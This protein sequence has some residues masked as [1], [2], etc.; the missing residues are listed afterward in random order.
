MS[1]AEL[2]TRIL[3]GEDHLFA[4]IVHR[5]SGYVWALCSS[6]IRNPSDCEDVTQEVF[7]QCYRRLDTLR[8]AAAF[9]QWLSQLA[10]RHCLMWLRTSARRERHLAEYEEGIEA[11]QGRTGEAA[12]ENPA[13]D[14][15]HQG[16]WKAVDA[17]PPDFREAVLLRFAEGYSTEE[18]SSFLG[19]TPAAMRKRIE[20]AQNMLKSMLWD[21]VEPAL[22]KRKHNESLA[23]GIMACVP[24]GKAPWL[25]VTGAVSAA[26]APAVSKL[27]LIGGIAVMSKKM[28]IGL[29]A[30]ALIL[31]LTLLVASRHGPRRAETRPIA[32]VKTGEAFQAAP[33]AAAGNSST[34]EPVKE[35]PSPAPPSAVAAKSAEVSD[36]QG[37]PASVSGLVSDGT[38]NPIA[39]A[40]IF[41]EIGRDR[42]CNDV[43]E[44]YNAKT[45]ADG[46]YEITGID[47]FGSAHVFAS[48]EDYVMQRGDMLDI[49]AGKNAKDVNFTLL[50]AAF[51]VAG[52]VVTENKTPIADASVDTL[53]Y[54][55]DESGLAQTAATGQTT[56]NISGSKFLFAVT[57]KNG[58]FKVAI[59]EEGLCDF[60]V[61]KAGYGPGFFPKIATG[62]TDALFVLRSGGAIAG[63]VTTAD[64]NPV[65][66]ATVRVSG[67]VLPGGLTP[68][69]VRIQ[70]IPV[71][72][73]AVTTDARGDY[74]A[75]GLG[76]DYVY[77]AAVP[78]P[79][80]AGEK[81]IVADNVRGHIVAAM[82]ELDE[83]MFGAQSFG[84]RR[85]DIRVK[86]GQT[87]QGVDLV[88]G[89]TTGATI[90]GTVTDR[91]SG[92][93]V[94]PVVVTAGCA[95]ADAPEEG[96]R[97][98]YWFQTKAGGSAVTNLDGSYVLQIQDLAEARN[99][100][101]SYAFMTEGGSAWEQP[102][103]EIALLE[104]GPGDE[105]ELNFTVD[106]P[107]TVPVRYVG[108]DGSP[109][110]GIDAAIRQAGGR[111]GCGG[112][113]V[114][115]ADG[116]VTFHGVRPFVDL[117]A[118]A[119]R[120]AGS[121]LQTIGV[122]D[123]F[124][125]QPGETVSEV[126]VVCRLSG[127]LGGVG[128]VLVYPDGRV[129]AN[130][131]VVCEGQRVDDTGPPMEGPV[132]TDANGAVH[133]PEIVPEGVYSLRVSFIDGQSGQPYHATAENV[134]IVAG[135]ITDVG[136]L[137]A[138]L[139]KDPMRM[140]QSADWG[141]KANEAISGMYSTALLDALPDP[142]LFWKTGLALY[143]VGRYQEALDVFSRMSETIKNDSLDSAAAL[144]W[145][146]HMLDLM[147]RRQEAVAAYS[148][149]ADMNVKDTMRHDQF[150]LVYSPSEYAQQRM[151]EPFARV[152]NLSP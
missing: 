52:R 151:N 111:G 49:S 120:R 6:Y 149:A 142:T 78:M 11:V 138:E 74:L 80:V 130:T 53:Y 127:G 8:N 5:Y 40:D 33:I 98:R 54:G 91:T 131:Q 102:D 150:G 106:G 46:K 77:T 39:Q 133:V 32:P 97:R 128:G 109:L 96:G 118:L 55:Y 36:G 70:A 66:G 103:E 93:P 47:T 86:A 51:Y 25:G 121:D 59:P 123:P 90:R 119:W 15:F 27:A 65:E 112:T 42:Y 126:T 108:V 73:V 43:A 113:L 83:D 82:R 129:V 1:E 38:A 136:T 141:R 63:K 21:Q 84:A 146:G 16:I 2:I 30:I 4:R 28:A 95:D 94:C 68:S 124:S 76:E 115:D 143:D 100:R 81:G 26:S 87:M 145:Q 134:E 57:D 17:L 41:L 23:R 44:T 64:G 20:R 117:Q 105:H 12:M 152:E 88:L 69:S 62:T 48:A 72:P 79:E 107:V 10:R 50:Q 58:I 24:L 19:I 92:K 71:A 13:R 61:S 45:G 148:A 104:L 56:G 31:G 135:A 116:R 101:I 114:S 9:G 147:G 37:K 125:G 67:E 29:G 14:E 110:E 18:A 122:S 60:R 22:A 137:V 34:M 99:F 139:E 85:T 132:I 89:S 75:E 3:S 7:V 35:K 140:L 144:I